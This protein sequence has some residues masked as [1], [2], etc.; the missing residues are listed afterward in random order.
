MK[1]RFLKIFGIVFGVAIAIFGAIIGVMALRGAFKKPYVEPSKLYFDLPY[2]ESSSSYYMDVTYYCNQKDTKGEPKSNIYYFILKAKPSDTTELNCRMV[3][4]SGSELINFC[5]KEGN[6]LSNADAGKVK[7]NKPVYF[8]ISN[9]FDNN[10]Y[11]YKISNGVVKIYFNSS[12]DLCNGYLTI[13]IDRQVSSVSLKDFTIKDS[14]NNVHTNG[15]FSYEKIVYDVVQLTGKPESWITPIKYY[16]KGADGSYIQVD[17]NAEYKSSTVYYTSRY[18]EELELVISANDPYPLVPIYAPENSNK[19]FTSV[20]GKTCEIFVKKGTSYFNVKDIANLHK[21]N[22]EENCNCL[23]DASHIY[24]DDE[25]VYRFKSNEPG[26]H[27]FYL[28][29]YPTYAIQQ[30]A[31][32]FFKN[33]NNTDNIIFNN[34]FAITRKV[35]ISVQNF[36]IQSVQFRDNDEVFNVGL[37]L[38]KENYFVLNDN[39]KGE[40]YTNLQ[41]HMF[42]NKGYE[43]ISRLNQIKFYEPSDFIEGHIK[44]TASNIGFENKKAEIILDGKN[45]I[46]S[47]FGNEKIDGTRNYSLKFIS[48]GE[49]LNGQAI[50]VNCVLVTIKFDEVGAN[51]LQ[52]VF[53]V[54]SGSKDNVVKLDSATYKIFAGNLL[55][56]TFTISEGEKFN[57]STTNLLVKYM[58][59]DNNQEST[60]SIGTIKV[61]SYLVFTDRFNNKNSLFEVKSSGYGASKV[62]SVLP[63]DKQ[64]SLYL[65]LFVVNE[66]YNFVYTDKYVT[67]S[68]DP[69]NTTYTKETEVDDLKIKYT[70]L[71]NEVISKTSEL[72]VSSL[73]TINSGS[74]ALPLTF[75]KDDGN[76]KVHTVGLYIDKGGKTYRLAGYIKDGN[77]INNIKPLDNVMGTQ[78]LYTVILSYSYDIKTAEDLV[79]FLLDAT[80]FDEDSENN[81]NVTVDETRVFNLDSF[82]KDGNKIVINIKY[83]D[84][85]DKETVNE[86]DELEFIGSV[87]TGVFKEDRSIPTKEESGIYHIKE[88]SDTHTFTVEI[89][90]DSAFY[91]S[92]LL[93][94]F[95]GEDINGN[96]LKLNK[97]GYFKLHINLYNDKNSL[98]QTGVLDYTLNAGREITSFTTNNDVINLY[99]EFLSAKYLELDIDEDGVLNKFLAFEFKTKNDPTDYYVGTVDNNKITGYYFQIVF[100]YEE[101][102]AVSSQLVIRSTAVKEYVIKN[103]ENIYHSKDYKIQFIVRPMENRG[104]IYK[105]VCIQ[106]VNKKDNT[107]IIPLYD[108]L[109]LFGIPLFDDFFSAEPAD[110][111]INEF[112]FRASCVDPDILDIYDVN[113]GGGGYQNRIAI[114]KAGTL[115]NPL[116]T[117][118]ILQNNTISSTRTAIDIEILS[119]IF[120]KSEHSE[121]EIADNEYAIYAGEGSAIKYGYN[122]NGNFVSLLN[123]INDTEMFGQVLDF[124]IKPV[125]S[126]YGVE[127]LTYTYTDKNNFVGNAQVNDYLDFIKILDNGYKLVAEKP[128]DWEQLD[129]VNE[130]YYKFING[131]YQK[132]ESLYVGYRQ[133]T[134]T[135]ISSINW[136]TVDFESNY[137][138]VYNEEGQKYV[139]IKNVNTADMPTIYTAT[140]TWEDGKIY[141]RYNTVAT[142]RLYKTSASEYQWKMVREPDY[143]LESFQFDLTAKSVVGEA[144][145]RYTYLSTVKIEKNANNLMATDEVITYYKG[146]NLLLASLVGATDDANINELQTLFKLTDNTSAGNSANFELQYYDT[147]RSEWTKLSDGNLLELSSTTLE[148]GEYDARIYYNSYKYYEFKFKV[149]ENLIYNATTDTKENT[150]ANPHI[151]T[152]GSA[153]TTITLDNQIEYFE[154]GEGSV[155]VNTEK[156]YLD[157]VSVSPTNIAKENVSYG[158]LPESSEY[159][160]IITLSDKKLNLGWVQFAGDKTYAVELTAA[161]NGKTINAVYYVKVKSDFK[162]T[163]TNELPI[164]NAYEPIDY[165]INNYF[166]IKNGSTVLTITSFEILNQYKKVEL[167]EAPDSWDGYYVVKDGKFVSVE[168]STNFDDKEVYFV[169]LESNN[170]TVSHREVS[171]TEKPNSW[172]GYYVLEGGEH[173]Q[174]PHNAEFDDTKTYYKAVLTF[175]NQVGGSICF[176]IQFKINDNSTERVITAVD[177]SGNNIIYEVLVNNY[178]LPLKENA[179]LIGDG[180]ATTSFDQLFTLDWTKIKQIDVEIKDTNVNTTNSK[181]MTKDSEYLLLGAKSGVDAI[182][183]EIALTYTNDETFTYVQELRVIPACYAVIDYSFKDLTEEI[184]MSAVVNVSEG[185]LQLSQ[186]MPFD[187]ALS[188]EVLDISNKFKVKKSQ[189]DLLVEN[190][191]LQTITVVG[192]IGYTESDLSKVTTNGT[193]I[194][195]GELTNIGYVIFR[196]SNDLASC[197]YM[198]KVT[199]VNI[200]ASENYTTI[201]RNNERALVTK[202][203]RVGETAVDSIPAIQKI[204][205]DKLSL[206]EIS[207]ASGLSEDLLK[208]VSISFYLTS[209]IGENPYNEKKVGYDVKDIDFKDILNPTIIKVAVVITNDIK[210]VHIMNYEI[211]LLPNVKVTPNTNTDNITTKYS[212]VKIVSTGNHYE[213]NLNVNYTY[214]GTGESNEIL[215]SDLFTVKGINEGIEV[216]IELTGIEIIDLTGTNSSNI[217]VDG[218]VLKLINNI[219]KDITFK[220]VLD[221]NGL[222]VTVNVTYESFKNSN[223]TRKYVL[224]WNGEV[225]DYVLDFSTLVPNYSGAYEGVISGVNNTYSDTTIDFSEFVATDAKIYKTLTITL[226]DISDTPTYI[227]D[228]ELDPSVNV[229]VKKGVSVGDSISTIING[230]SSKLDVQVISGDDDSTVDIVENFTQVIIKDKD[231]NIVFATIRIMNAG[232]KTLKY[233]YT[234]LDGGDYND[235]ISKDT[236]Y[237]SYENREI[238]LSSSSEGTIG[239]ISSASNYSGLLV[240]SIDPTY[241]DISLYVTASK[242]YETTIQYLVSSENKETFVIGDNLSFEEFV[243]GKRFD[244]Q[245]VYSVATWEENKYYYYDKSNNKYLA[246][247]QEYLFNRYR[248]NLYTKVFTKIADNAAFDSTVT[249]YKLD[250]TYQ[251]VVVDSSNFDSL[252]TNGL[253]TSSWKGLEKTST[254][255]SA[256]TYYYSVSATSYYELSNVDS[257]DNYIFSYLFGKHKT[258]YFTRHARTS[259]SFKGVVMNTYVPF[260]K[261]VDKW[262]ENKYYI[263]NSENLTYTLINESDFNTTAVSM[264]YKRV[265]VSVNDKRIVIA[266]ESIL[267][268]PDTLNTLEAQVYYKSGGEWIADDN[269]AFAEITNNTIYFMQTGEIKIVFFNKTGLNLEY[270]VNIENKEVNSDTIT[271]NKTV[272]GYI[273]SENVEYIST[274]LTELK[275]GFKLATLTFSPSEQNMFALYCYNDNVNNY[276]LINDGIDGIIVDGNK[277]K[278]Q[279]YFENNVNL[280]IKTIQTASVEGYTYY[281]LYLITTNGVVKTIRL[282]VT[283]VNVN[284][285]SELPEIWANTEGNKLSDNG[286]WITNGDKEIEGVKDGIIDSK[287][288]IDYT[289]GNYRIVYNGAYN[290]TDGVAISSTST[291]IIKSKSGEVF[292]LGGVD[293]EKVITLYYNLEYKVFDASKTPEPEDKDIYVVIKTIEF[294][295]IVKNNVVIGGGEGFVQYDNAFNGTIYLNN[296]EATTSGTSTTFS[297]DLMKSTGDGYRDEFITYEDLAPLTQMKLNGEST[298]PMMSYVSNYLKFEI[299]EDSYGDSE[300][301][302]NGVLKIKHDKNGTVKLKVSAKY[303]PSYYKIF[304][305]DIRSTI[306]VNLRYTQD[307]YDENG[308]KSGDPFTLVT[309]DYDNAN[310]TSP[311]RLSKFITGD[312]YQDTQKEIFENSTDKLEITYSYYVHSDINIMLENLDKF[313]EETEFA[314]EKSGDP[315]K[316]NLPSVPMDGKFY[317]VTYKVEFTVNNTLQ[318]YLYNIK[319]QNPVSVELTDSY[320]TKQ[321]TVGIG[322]ASVGNNLY[323]YN[324]EETDGKLT[325]SL[326]NKAGNIITD[327]TNKVKLSIYDNGN[328]ASVTNR[329][330]VYFEIVKEE[331]TA[332]YYIDL[333]KGVLAGVDGKVDFETTDDTLKVKTLFSNAMSFDLVFVDVSNAPLHTITGWTMN[334]TTTI[335][336]TNN[337]NLTDIFTVTE[338][339]QELVGKKFSAVVSNDDTINSSIFGLTGTPS[340]KNEE[341]SISRT[342]SDTTYSYTIKSCIITSNTASSSFYNSSIKVYYIVTEQT[343]FIE[344][345]VSYYI[346]EIIDTL[347]AESHTIDLSE[348]LKVFNSGDWTS[349][350][351]C[352]IEVLDPDN[353]HSEITVDDETGNITITKAFLENLK[354]SGETDYSFEIKVSGGGAHR[355]FE[356]RITLTF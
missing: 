45:A 354:N 46:L 143:E 295:I 221:F 243:Y 48:A 104:Q 245:A 84:Q 184:D 162:V 14:P 108:V 252:K 30:E 31:E 288:K 163:Q 281:D 25:G 212:N 80:W 146:T 149:V 125:S 170:L 255:D 130:N 177:E 110:F 216:D 91:E 333:T 136:D 186:T 322:A 1:K 320:T 336:P 17:E 122:N 344:F 198:L 324:S 229:E 248:T 204:G 8:E 341:K 58:G 57:S 121:V 237:N 111:D 197:Y 114:L 75:V 180:K 303:S 284:L 285:P 77:F 228:I 51:D 272:S 50:D 41:V 296:Y 232:N 251:T 332:N 241:K 183:I 250:G 338:L 293:G 22:D 263:Y 43:E 158:S 120:V 76:I 178:K 165:D 236:N 351:G 4:E 223:T 142:L 81:T 230:T 189:D 313:I 132:I 315:L 311:I 353:K 270:L 116:T 317:F 83:A 97:D 159:K 2:D 205:V 72:N 181:T 151:L 233:N 207:L 52:L 199:P 155:T 213:Y 264:I 321:V 182:N 346:S 301:T 195:F 302:S 287:D 318:T 36:G 28:V 21:T 289:T 218:Y 275:K 5:D 194:T 100:K 215:L 24:L 68:V 253:Y 297:V 99:F 323:L 290:H 47:N 282:Y 71:D 347:P 54:V 227:F 109:G 335:S 308:Y 176:E 141:K 40:Q 220:L 98:L 257:E 352:T 217:N 348:S 329:K 214:A 314:L 140:P 171:L 85:L 265:E 92:Q 9:Q 7:I 242:T 133:L 340:S 300:I 267:L 42:N 325:K 202:E 192:G 167:E 292:D 126:G 152:W 190:S 135:E 271:L 235:F 62:F 19:P 11:D 137:Y 260:N 112:D 145:V 345:P 312:N 94:L 193:T 139:R 13:N 101:E 201:L 169:K 70:N 124:D 18:N 113:A 210:I 342:I 90:K 273:E 6:Y 185:E 256:L 222:K 168:D 196:L 117:Q 128:G 208:N 254:Y 16:V 310:D 156:Y 274:T 118:I 309:L 307:E 78:E 203:F 337:K 154:F 44:L 343:K 106:A 164:L 247:S 331:G 138:F 86:N 38:F 161:A 37:D 89:K 102:E 56:E 350:T 27:E 73:V 95:A 268:N 299:M 294:K 356:V 59:K 49:D 349:S 29:T 64:A 79:N 305:L 115:E 319:L 330:D 224:G 291:S 131:T 173:K 35:T 175:N 206:E 33:E 166:T 153:N 286:L 34:E 157:Y 69:E 238:S 246:V 63:T 129:F 20:D 12:N 65:Y 179:K 261:D 209:I 200:N 53:K 306:D 32:E 60:Y 93:S 55:S 172:S 10:I 258:E 187:I 239:F 87:Y 147:E 269:K 3:V 148:N 259:D 96:L 278:L 66:D 334:V 160:D 61:G 23:D 191:R 249:Y 88:S 225:F 262:E 276:I 326:F 188:G 211:T 219:S 280:T 103:G 105:G 298:N 244:Y 283:D 277:P 240:F 134:E 234:T 266:D 279:Y 107:D 39:T 226:T 119:E 327:S 339:G 355:I 67:I 150:I 304:N 82:D 123:T 26:Q 127:K 74:Y 231:N 316:V 15:K 174:V 328:D 144:K